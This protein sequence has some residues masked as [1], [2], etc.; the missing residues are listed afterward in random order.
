MGSPDDYLGCPWAHADELHGALYSSK[1]DLRLEYHQI[2]INEHD[3]HR[4]TLRHIYEF[5][6]IP[7]GLNNTSGTYQSCIQL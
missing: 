4:V 1:I 7:L 2:R 5:L 6:A 3:T